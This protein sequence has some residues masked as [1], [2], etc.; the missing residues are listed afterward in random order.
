MSNPILLPI[1]PWLARSS[2]PPERTDEEVRAQNARLYRQ[3]TDKLRKKTDEHLI[4]LIAGRD[5]IQMSLTQPDTIKENMML[6]GAV[7]GRA[8][9]AS[10]QNSLVKCVTKSVFKSPEN[11]FKHAANPETGEFPPI[12]DAWK[13]VLCDVCWVPCDDQVPDID[14]AL[15]ARQAE[16][17]QQ[18]SR[19]W[20][21]AAVRMEEEQQARRNAVW[22]IDAMKGMTAEELA[23]PGLTQSLW[24]KLSPLPPD[25][26]QHIVD[27]GVAWGFTWYASP[28]MREKAGTAWPEMWDMMRQHEMRPRRVPGRR[29]KH[30]SIDGVHCRGHL[31]TV[32]GLWKEH[33]PEVPSECDFHQ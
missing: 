7:L 12:L 33:W 2:S 30:A 23:A 21:W 28:A 25:W 18:T 15:K 13:L 11:L 9:R 4:K 22:F 10:D 16:E 27:E 5:L 24:V 19:A 29:L 1:L 17:E 3:S 32:K 8:P 6:R 20:A 31:D 14:A 26:I